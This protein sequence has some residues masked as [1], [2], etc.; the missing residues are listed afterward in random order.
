MIHQKIIFRTILIGLIVL[1]FFIP[2]SKAESGKKWEVEKPMIVMSGI[3][4][5]IT[6]KVEE[7]IDEMLLSVNGHSQLYKIQNHEIQI[8]F[9][10]DQETIFLLESSYGIVEVD[11]DPIPIWFSIIPPLIAILAALLFKEVYTAL[12]LGIFMGTTTIWFYYGESFLGALF[13]GFF[14][15]ITDY[16]I[17]ALNDAGHLS[18]IVFSMLIGGMV[19]IITKNGGMQGVVAYLSRYAQTKKSGQLITWLLGVSIFF[20]DYANTLVVGNTMRPVADRLKIS[21]EKLAYLVDSTAAPIA[22]I[23]LITTWVG[24]E[25]SYIQDGIK[26]L[27]LDETPYLVFL[28]SLQYAFYPVFTLGFI[29]ILIFTGRDYG[30]MHK[31]E[32]NMGN[33]EIKH[34]SIQ[35]SDDTYEPKSGVKPKAFN[36]L[37]PVLVVVFG[38]IIALF[39]TGLESAQWS[40]DLSFSRNLSQIIGQADSYRALLW[41]SLA[42]MFVA[43]ILS[44]S[45]KLLTLKES[46]ESMVDG[47]K[48]MLTAVIILTLAWALAALTENIHTAEF[49]SSSLVNLQ[50]SPYLIP[51]LAFILAALVAFSTGSSWG[52]MAI[53]YPLMIP[54]IWLISEEAALD[55]DSSIAL[56]HN[57]VS[58]ILAGSVMGDH[59][60]PI[61]DTTIMSSLAS[62]CNHI[63]HVR[64]QL[65]YAITVGMVALFIGTIPAAFGMPVILSYIL[66]FI[67][68]YTI[69]RYI[70][71]K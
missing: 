11:I 70:G 33:P 32:Q 67:L 42:G 68:L 48:M 47:F 20:D 27:E 35:S 61:S 54:A 69:V 23:A 29:L 36:A 55:Y 63:E 12:F 46:M 17:V 53:L 10:V 6:I 19:H 9:L 5:Y 65:P 30:P 31:A 7:H 44:L 37:L 57:V 1:L 24:A 50:I 8:P 16:I 56:F 15:I 14:S 52:T 13:K 58:V 66:G 60:S 62:Q 28:H 4:N 39:V 22:S 2:F 64:T 51:G 40:S 34:H 18:I 21:R 26:Q 38:T 3:D 25:L 43:I 45:Q 59:C 49:I 71:R 41:S